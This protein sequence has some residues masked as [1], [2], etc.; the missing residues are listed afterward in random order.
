MMN[1]A[2]RIVAVVLGI[3][4]RAMLT[5]V[6]ADA[7]SSEARTFGPTSEVSYTVPAFSFSEFELTNDNTSQAYNSDINTGARFCTLINC[8]LLA[9]VQLPAGALVTRIEV[10]GCDTNPAFNFSVVLRRS[11]AH[12]GATTAL[13]SADS[14]G[15]PGCVFV[16]GN[17]ATPETI[18]NRNNTYFLDYID[19]GTNDAS[20]RFTAVRIFYTLQVSPAPATATFCDVLTS[21]PFFQF[22]EA[23]VRSGITVGCDGSNYRPDDPLTRGQMAVFLSKALGLHFAP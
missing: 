7:Q 5:A 18:D 6:W 2:F 17:L 3:A 19:G 21:H 8:R 22:I 10:D 15:V 12:G 1:Q 11:Q 9:P 20:L 4:L 23:L 14:A 16:T 13:T